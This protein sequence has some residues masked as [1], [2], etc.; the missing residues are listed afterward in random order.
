M[1]ETMLEKIR[2]MLEEIEIPEEA[3]GCISV[4]GGDDVVGSIKDNPE[5]QK[6][7]ILMKKAEKEEDALE[8]ALRLKVVTKEA[9]KNIKTPL[10]ETMEIMNSEKHDLMCR[11]KLAD[12]T[13]NL[14]WGS[15]Y[16]TIGV[17]HIGDNEN[18]CIDIRKG[19]EIVVFDHV[20]EEMAEPAQMARLVGTLFNLAFLG[21]VG[22]CGCGG[23]CHGEE[24]VPGEFN[25][26]K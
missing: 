1:P 6:L 12:G 18:R 17:D 4:D 3:P 5:L 11:E 23:H 25:D 8:R 20:P 15:I 16:E 14:F 10:P 19:W 13:S 24:S 26:G 2:K 7:F 21:G 9:A 22:G